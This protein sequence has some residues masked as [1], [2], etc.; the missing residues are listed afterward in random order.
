[1]ETLALKRIG[2]T[3]IVALEGD[4]TRQPVEAVVNSAN[5]ELQHDE[6]VATAIV[7]TGGRVIQEESDVWIREHGPVAPGN[8]AVTTGGMLQASHVI[9]AVGPYFTQ[10][11][12]DAT[13]AAAVTAALDIAH[14]R[15]LR[16]LAFPLISSGSRGYPPD[17]AA[18]V[19]TGAIEGWLA[20]HPDALAEVRLVGFDRKHA[21]M[22]A[23]CLAGE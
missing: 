14:E 19:I 11:E 17:L 16:T 9:H 8:A 22:F 12:S 20:E 6:G 15:G 2:G 7:R 4:V 3:T 1:M 10:G 5:E 23:E 21:E 13:L 18:T